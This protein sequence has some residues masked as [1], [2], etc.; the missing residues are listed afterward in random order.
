MLPVDGMGD[1]GASLFDAETAAI[2]RSL[3]DERPRSMKY[4]IKR[5][6]SR[7]EE[8]PH[9]SGG[10]SVGMKRNA[11]QTPASDLAVDVSFAA[12][13]PPLVSP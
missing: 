6:L 12:I 10:S 1:L 4:V 9:G 8:T 5:G 3:H 7:A 2:T 13:C 11:A